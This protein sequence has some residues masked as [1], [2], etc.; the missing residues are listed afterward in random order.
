MRLKSVLKLTVRS[1]QF[2]GGLT[3]K[4]KKK[5]SPKNSS[6]SFSFLLLLLLPFFVGVN[7]TNKIFSQGHHF[8][9]L[10]P[11]ASNSSNATAFFPSLFKHRPIF[12]NML[13][14]YHYCRCCRC[15]FSTFAASVVVLNIY[16]VPWSYRVEIIF[17]VAKLAGLLMI[18]FMGIIRL[19]QGKPSLTFHY[20][21]IVAI[22]CYLFLKRR[23]VH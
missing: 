10:S 5:K 18:I 11:S 13:Q 22:T 15:C 17:D 6:R 23:R 4:K 12:E 16:S 20:N 7:P 14:N 8:V 2:F 3:K 19:A 1:K 9:V 21:I